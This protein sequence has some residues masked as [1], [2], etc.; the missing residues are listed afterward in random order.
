MGAATEDQR[1][2]IGAERRDEDEK[3]PGNDA[4]QSERDDDAPEDAPWR[5]IEV[6]GSFNQAEV[7]FLEGRIEREHHEWQE[8]IEEPE[9]DREVGIEDGDRP[10]AKPE[11]NPQLVDH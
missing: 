10:I 1:R 5:R 4:R 6:V 3:A 11:A 9:E 7:E 2:D 8:G